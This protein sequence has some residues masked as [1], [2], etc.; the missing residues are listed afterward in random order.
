MVQ[1]NIATMLKN[2]LVAD[3]NAIGTEE[4]RMAET[5]I[6]R[7]RLRQGVKYFEFSNRFQRDLNECY[8][9]QHFTK[10]GLLQSSETHLSLTKRGRLLSNDVFAQFL[11]QNAN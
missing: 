8:A 10:L 9:T 4:E 3:C 6:L 7:L 1:N 2:P 5:I 11:K